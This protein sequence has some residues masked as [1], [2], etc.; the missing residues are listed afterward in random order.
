MKITSERI[1]IAAALVAL[2]ICVVLAFHIVRS[3]RRAD[4]AELGAKT[5]TVGA[6]AGS[7][8]VITLDKAH[9]GAAADRQTH[10]DN[11]HANSAAPGADQPLDPNLNRSGRRGMC[12]HDVNR[13]T[14]ACVQ[15]L[16]KPDPSFRCARSGDTR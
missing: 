15:L 4:T 1:L 7:V 12:Q 11:A 13:C 9:Q 2:V 14:A 3:D 16:G 8:A 6:K 10:E 5:A